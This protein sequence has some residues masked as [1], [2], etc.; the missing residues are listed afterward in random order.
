MGSM[1]G[2][3]SMIRSLRRFLAWILSKLGVQDTAAILG[4]DS[5][6]FADMALGENPNE[7]DRPKSWPILLF[8]AFALGGPYLIYR[9]LKSSTTGDKRK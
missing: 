1:F 7:A 3:T 5:D 6:P 2:D 8:F 9:L 4:E